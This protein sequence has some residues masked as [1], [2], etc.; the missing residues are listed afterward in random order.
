MIKIKYLIDWIVNFFKYVFK[1]EEVAQNDSF[2]QSHRL[3]FAMILEAIYQLDH[4]LLSASLLWI[5]ANNSIAQALPD[6][7]NTYVTNMKLAQA[8][9]NLQEAQKTI[10][11]LQELFNQNPIASKE[12]LISKIDELHTEISRVLTVAQD[13]TQSVD[14]LKIKTLYLE[15]TD[16]FKDLFAMKIISGFTR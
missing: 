16:I 3:A 11:H 6:S 7:V 8:I 10:E 14:L 12:K 1:K 9:E 13:S 5:N 2:A 4:M 15:A